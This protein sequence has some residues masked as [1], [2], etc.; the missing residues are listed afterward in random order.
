MRVFPATDPLAAL[1]L[2]G[3]LAF[4]GCSRDRYQKETTSG[5]IYVQMNAPITLW[6]TDLPIVRPVVLKNMYHRIVRRGWNTYVFERVAWWRTEAKSKWVP[7]FTVKKS[8]AVPGDLDLVTVY[9]P[10]ATEGVDYRKCPI[11]AYPLPRPVPSYFHRMEDSRVREYF[12]LTYTLRQIEISRNSSSDSKSEESPAPVRSALLP[13]A[14]GLVADAPEDPWRQIFYWDA[15]VANGGTDTLRSEMEQWRPRFQEQ[16]VLRDLLPRFDAALHS[17]ELSDSGRNAQDLLEFLI[18]PS[19]ELSLPDRFSA[20]PRLLEYEECAQPWRPISGYKPLYFAIQVSAKVFRTGAAM[21]LLQGDRAKALETASAIHHMGQMMRGTLIEELLGCAVRAIGTG[22]LELCVLDGCET[23]EEVEAAWEKLEWLNERE[24]PRTRSELLA[25]QP[26]AFYF[27]EEERPKNPYLLASIDEVLNRQ[28]VAAA[29]FQLV[30]MAASGRHRFLSAGSFPRVEGE[31]DLLP[32]GVPPRDPFSDGNLRFAETSKG[33]LC[34][35]VGPDRSN[36]D[37][38][39]HYDPTNGVRSAGDVILE[40]PRERKYP[41]PREGVHASD[42]E[43]LLRQ[44]PNGLPADIYADTRG[45]P[46]G[47]TNTS[48]VLVYSYGPDTDESIAR[49]TG[50]DYPSEVMYDPTNGLTSNGDMFFAVPTP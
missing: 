10:E 16:M 48:P 19:S 28:G 29:L 4:A 13:L 22:G 49:E 39:V 33:L 15:L 44:F 38:A 1:I 27:S 30:R 9:A 12:R 43:D 21:F 45:R 7:E 50:D 11:K 35:S 17:L 20:L 3:V 46:L 32:S 5:E 34:W 47:V 6:E 8:S 14:Q 41:F 36:D 23:P 26:A 18:V 42:R 2:I 37:G 25:L 31:F 24:R 40:T